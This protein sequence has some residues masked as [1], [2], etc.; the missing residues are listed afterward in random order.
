MRPETAAVA[1]S[2]AAYGLAVGLFAPGYL[3]LVALLAGP[4][5]RFVY[6]PFLHLLVTGPGVLLTGF[7]LLTYLVL[8]RHA[9]H[10]PLWHVLAIGTAG[11][12]LAGAAQQKG[13][14][15]H[16]YPSFA[17]A[18]LL[19]AL[20]AV[21]S[22]PP[23][24]LAGRLYRWAAAATLAVSLA[25]VAVQ[26]AAVALGAGRDAERAQ[27]EQ[28]ITLVRD[29]ARGQPVFVFSYHIGSVYPLIN[30]SGARS[31]SRFP[32]LWILAADYRDELMRSAPLEYRLPEAMPP[33]ERFLGRAVREDLE[34][35]RPRLLIVYR[36]ARDRPQNG[37]R[38]LDYVAY[39]SRDPRIA[40]IF[41]RYQRIARTGDYDVFE[42]VPDG[43]A[44]TGPPMQAE[45]P[46]QDIVPLT[47]RRRL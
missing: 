14:R 9:K 41:A 27:L 45:T 38:R 46:T 16:F 13:L 47:G 34:R 37:Y 20:A 15:Y 6:D 42:R 33:S 1:A 5:S 17:L 4:Y 22:R 39:F 23:G 26:N 28:L 32:H 11:C 29:R 2:L 35:T 24:D 40:Q 21:D 18:T 43:A 36:P 7:A 25:V 12:L 8:A 10:P 31:A 19:L 30:Y 44:R 3:R